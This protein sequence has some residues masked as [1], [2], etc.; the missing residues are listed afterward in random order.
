V[1]DLVDELIDVIKT[2]DGEVDDASVLGYGVAVLLFVVG[3]VFIVS[4]IPR[5]VGQ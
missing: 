4:W 3:L 5:V 1:G 2:Y